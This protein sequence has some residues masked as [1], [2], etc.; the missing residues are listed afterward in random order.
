MKKIILASQ[1]PRRKELLEQIRVDFE[2]QPS[3]YEEDLSQDLSPEKLVKELSLGKAKDIASK[4]ENAIVIGVDEIIA[5]EGKV[6][7]KP[8]TK[9]KNFEMLKML[10]GKFHEVMTAYTIIE[11]DTQKTVTNISITKVKFKEL[12]DEMI[13]RY[14]EEDNPID[15]AAGYAIQEGKGPLLVEKIDGDYFTIPGLPLTILA[16]DLREFGINVL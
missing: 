11:T 4:N 6:L 14:I 10:S 5:F 2:V 15:R 8:H 16:D 1:S 13:Q 7:G 9:E 3:D 12:S